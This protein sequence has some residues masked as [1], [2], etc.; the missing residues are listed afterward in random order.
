M[1]T[2]SLCVALASVALMIALGGVIVV[3]VVTD[4][5]PPSLKRRGSA[6]DRCRALH[7][8]EWSAGHRRTHAR[9]E[10]YIRP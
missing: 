10:V 7:N 8:V 4:L 2:C 9:L 1:N 3:I 6:V 5:R